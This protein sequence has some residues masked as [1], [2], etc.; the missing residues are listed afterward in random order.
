MT[1][2]YK[3]REETEPTHSWYIEYRN[4]LWTDASV[5]CV[6]V[7]FLE[8]KIKFIEL[9]EEAGYQQEK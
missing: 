4:L 5:K 3:V 1:K 6:M 8:H 9:L 2:V 7:T